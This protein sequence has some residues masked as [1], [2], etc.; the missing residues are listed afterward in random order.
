MVGRD[1]L[2]VEEPDEPEPGILIPPSRASFK[3]F[4]AT[5]KLEPD[6]P[7]DHRAIAV[8]WNGYK[9]GYVPR[10]DNKVLYNLLKDG[11]TLQTK[12][13]LQLNFEP[14]PDHLYTYDFENV[15]EMRI[16][17]FLVSENG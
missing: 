2:V 9:M 1:L 10:K 16:R 17:V 13:R 4:P 14:E 7:Y 15:Y 8:Y 3:E 5:L 12:L 6:N 11:H